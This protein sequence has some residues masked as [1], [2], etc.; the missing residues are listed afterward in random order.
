MSRISIFVWYLLTQPFVEAWLLLKSLFEKSATLN[1]PKTWQFVF[2]FLAVG[3]FLAK[4]YFLVK[5][6]GVLLVVT[7]IKAEWER[8]YWMEL[9]RKRIE[10]RA[11]EEIKKQEGR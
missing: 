8:G 6:F 5:I 3:A 9:H 11:E 2:L 10:K 4:N 7:V 1:Y